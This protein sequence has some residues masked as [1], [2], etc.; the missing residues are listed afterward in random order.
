MTA[1]DKITL[2]LLLLV[3]PGLLWLFF[4]AIHTLFRDHR[5][6][7]REW[8]R[9]WAK[10]RQ[11]ARLREWYPAVYERRGMRVKR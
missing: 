6:A 11:T 7:A 1:V 5:G 4:T 2:T 9:Q 10:R 8:R 3:M